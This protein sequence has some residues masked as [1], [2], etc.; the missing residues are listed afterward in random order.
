[1]FQII[2]AMFKAAVNRVAVTIVATAANKI[3]AAAA[4]E[5]AE[6]D[7]EIEIEAMKLETQGMLKQ[8]QALRLRAAGIHTDAPAATALPALANLIGEGN[9]QPT[10][11]TESLQLA[12]A[13][14]PGRIVTVAIAGKAKRGP[15]RPPKTNETKS[16]ESTDTNGN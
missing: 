9:N 14:T 11:K 1:M 4:I 16:T 2:R 3:E 12:E 6:I 10:T 7:A 13:P 15:G 5:K 8:A